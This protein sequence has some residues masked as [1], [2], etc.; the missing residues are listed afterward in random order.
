MNNAT[1]EMLTILNLFL[2]YVCIHSLT[3]MVSSSCKF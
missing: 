3:L 1:M 2:S